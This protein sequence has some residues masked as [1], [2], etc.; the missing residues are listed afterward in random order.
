MIKRFAKLILPFVLGLVL[1]QGS[2]TV[3]FGQEACLKVFSVV[4]TPVYSQGTQRLEWLLNFPVDQGARETFANRWAAARARA[5]RVNWLEILSGSGVSRA[6]SQR[7]AALAR[8]NEL[9]LSP[10]MTIK[11]AN[12]YIDDAKKVTE[13]NQAIA[14]WLKAEAVVR[15]W[16]QRR[17]P[18]SKERVEAL[19][20]ILGNGL[21]FNG[22]PA[23]HL[24]ETDFP[25]YFAAYK[26]QEL[27]HAM[28]QLDLWYA[29]QTHSK[30]LDPIEIAT[31]YYQRLLTIHPFPDGNGRTS[32]LVLDWI[33]ELHGL[34]PATF[35]SL[36]DA[37]T[38]RTHNANDV[39][40]EVALEKVTGA[41]ER[42]MD[43]LDGAP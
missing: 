9:R 25:D 38:P 36:S 13:S 27:G 6:E 14:N 15:K 20:G 3:T 21:A 22:F 7:T 40:I 8:I 16:V 17:V 10:S 23:G 5:S 24:R 29:E 30:R 12:P 43:L 28:S 26:A 11:M 18:P 31:R 19:N 33:L 4:E 39:Q 34:P 1:V 32:R 42:T 37:H 2:S 35:T 41:I